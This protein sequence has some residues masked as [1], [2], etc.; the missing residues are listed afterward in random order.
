MCCGPDH[1]GP[2]PGW[3]AGTEEVETRAEVRARQL[4][5]LASIIRP[6]EQSE[7]GPRPRRSPPPRSTERGQG[8][9][10]PRQPVSLPGNDWDG[11]WWQL[12]PAQ[13]FDAWW[14]H[15]TPPS[16]NI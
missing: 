2:P 6:A 15:F 3:Y 14:L 11:D 8:R 5:A 7:P 9:A 1:I 12:D 4:A 13:D 10:I 16:R